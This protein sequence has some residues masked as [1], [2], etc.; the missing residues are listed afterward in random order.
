MWFRHHFFDYYDYRLYFLFCVPVGWRH[1]TMIIIRFPFALHTLAPAD[2]CSIIP[3]LTH[4]K[5]EKNCWKLEWMHSHAEAHGIDSTQMPLE[6]AHIQLEFKRAFC[7]GVKYLQSVVCPI[8]SVRYMYHLDY[9]VCRSLCEIFKSRRC[10]C[11]VL[12]HIHTLAIWWSGD[13]WNHLC[14]HRTEH[15]ICLLRVSIT[16]LLSNI[17][18]IRHAYISSFT[19]TAL[20]KII[21]ANSKGK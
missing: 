8:H 13:T 16:S 14:W 5:I 2:L 19:A 3:S 12:A 10:P 20:T 11:S 9:V 7:K 17:S 1:L 21:R 6:S 4:A 18:T 15:N